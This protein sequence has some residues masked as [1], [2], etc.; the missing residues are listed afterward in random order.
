MALETCLPPLDLL[1]AYK[2]PQAHLRILCSVAEI[3]PAIAR[4]A[5][6]VQ[7]PSL[8]RHDR[9]TGPFWQEM[10]GASSPSHAVSLAPLP[11]TQPTSP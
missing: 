5:P 11:K 10:R 1:L 8:L 4:L 6:S 7:T 3:N 2:R 9:T